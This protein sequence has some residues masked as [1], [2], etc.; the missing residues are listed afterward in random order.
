[1]YAS[2]TVVIMEADDKALGAIIRRRRAAA[3]MSQ[4]DMSERLGLAQVVY[5]RI[6]LG[7]RAVR[8]IELRD[9]AAALGLSADELLRDMAPVSPEEMVT[10]AEARRDAAYAALHDYGQGFLDAV[11][12]LEESEHGAAVSDDEFLDNADDLVDWLKRSQPAFIGLK[13]SAD[14][15]PAVK[16]ALTNTAA[17]VVIYPTKGDPDE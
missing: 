2:G 3:G 11:V 15:I 13:A 4:K 8:A 5:G 14:L 17:S 10:R 1:M 16:E 6:E 7:T 9:I 12:A